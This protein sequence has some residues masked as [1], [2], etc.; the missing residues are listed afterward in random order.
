M[1][2]ENFVIETFENFMKFFF[3][4]AVFESGNQVLTNWIFVLTM[5]QTLKYEY[6][7]VS[8]FQVNE[9]FVKLKMELSMNISIGKISRI[10]PRLHV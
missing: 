4:K 9:T 6:D 10:F 5:S 2:S 1:G 8:T 7:N 3:E